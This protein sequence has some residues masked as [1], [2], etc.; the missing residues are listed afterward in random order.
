MLKDLNHYEPKGSSMPRR[1]ITALLLITFAFSLSGCQPASDPQADEADRQAA[2]A[3]LNQMLAEK[4]RKEDAAA[5]ERERQ[6]QIAEEREAARIAEANR[7]HYAPQRLALAA[8]PRHWATITV[9]DINVQ[10]VFNSSWSG[11]HLN[12]R[13][14]LLGQKPAINA[15]LTQ[16]GQYQVNL[17]D[18]SGANLFQFPV[19][20]HDFSWAPPGF[21]NGVPT[22]QTTGRVPVDLPVYEQAVQWNLT[23]SQ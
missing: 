17:Q 9:P 22:V 7:P 8:R 11:D 16:W 3:K 1:N 15:F 23:W 2:E 5:A 20:P 10:A 4:Q 12:Y 21:N 13:V 14:A 19:D 18:P 6:R